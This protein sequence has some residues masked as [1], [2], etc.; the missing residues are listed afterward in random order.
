[1]SRES[2]L[3]NRLDQSKLT[4]RHAGIYTSVIS[5]H[6]F[7]GFSINMMGVVVG[8]IIATYHLKPSQSGFLVSC[9]FYGMCLGALL[10]G[11]IA[12][13]FGRKRVFVTS[14]LIYS[15]FSLLCAVAPS[16]HSLLI[17]RMLQGIGLGVEVPVSLTYVNEFMPLKLRGLAVSSAT[18]FW[19]IA[20]V[21]AALLG[22][23]LLPVFG[24]RSMFIV[25][26]IPA[27]VVLLI[28]FS[29]PESVR[30]L[31]NKG[32]LDQAERIVDRLSTIPASKNEDS[33]EQT[34]SRKSIAEQISIKK[35]F[36]GKYAVQTIAVWL[37]LFICG[38]VF[39]GLGSWLPTI[40]V[41]MGYSFVRSLSYTAV[42]SLSGAVGSLVGGLF[43]D[44]LGYRLTLISFFFISG[45]SLMLWVTAPNASIMI[46]WGILTAFFGFGA[47][48]VVF[49]YVTSLY[50]TNVR[51][52]GTGWGA[53]WQRAGGIVAPFVLGVII[54]S[55]LPTYM[56]FFTLG[57]PTLIG[58]IVALTMT[59]EFRNKSLEQ[60]HEELLN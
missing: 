20:S 55:N 6:F 30:Y 4:K 59:V 51:A 58:G 19:T 8:G 29:V 9:V 41:K 57:I 16:Y 45:A 33:S 37:M 18:F 23:V 5:G 32:K 35:I 47:G 3:F 12:D 24:W 7:D 56:F 17:F 22:L 25:G 14:I 40:F 49:V 60:I 39:Y 52:T 34:V 13:K 38:F 15:V 27:I 11:P 44:K 2:T 50:P 26:F 42:I 36:K 10:G 1:M 21:V 54:Q 31:I 46:M 48:G 53:F 43:I 28:W